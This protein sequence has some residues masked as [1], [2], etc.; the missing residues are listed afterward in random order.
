MTCFNWIITGKWFNI[1]HRPKRVESTIINHRHLWVLP[2]HGTAKPHFAV[3]HSEVVRQLP[4]CLYQWRHPWASSISYTVQCTR[5]FASL[6]CVLINLPHKIFTISEHWTCS[7][8]NEGLRTC[9]HE[10]LVILQCSDIILFP[11]FNIITYRDFTDV[12]IHFSFLQISSLFIFGI[13]FYT[14]HITYWQQTAITL[15]SAIS[16]KDINSRSINIFDLT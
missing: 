1:I 7:L 4:C 11:I 14:A 10:W 9:V 16:P 15:T 2:K 3:P 6:V 5:W 13:Q 12:Y 8:F